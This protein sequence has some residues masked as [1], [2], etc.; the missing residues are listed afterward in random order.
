MDPQSESTFAKLYQLDERKFAN[1]P[2]RSLLFSNR[3]A[4]RLRQAGVVT[5]MDLLKM[6]P[7]I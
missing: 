1:D 5:V 4:K 3:T 7:K 2:V 6:T